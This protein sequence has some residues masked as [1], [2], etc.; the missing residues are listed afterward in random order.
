MKL[1][2]L[3]GEASGDSLASELIKAINET[4]SE[5]VECSGIGGSLMEEQGFN[6][7][8][9]M[10]QVSIVGILEVLPKIPHLMKIKKAVIQ[11]IE[12]QQPDAVITVDFPDFNFNIAK[13]LKKRGV[14]KG[15]IIHYVAPSV[16][17]WRASR[18][19]KMSEFLDG[20]MCLFPMEVPYFTEHH[21]KAAHVGH[22]IVV[23]RAK[24]ASSTAFRENNDIPDDTTT[25]GLFFGSRNNEFKD[26]ANIIK[27]AALL[28]DEDIEKINI[29][30]PTLPKLEYE[31]Q[32]I[33]KDFPLPVFVISNSDAKWSAIK[34]CDFAISV[35]GTIALELAYAGVPHVIC[36]K[37]N[38]ITSIILKLLVKVKFA[39]LANILLEKEAVPE[40]LQ[41]KCNPETIAIKAI[42]IIKSDELKKNQIEEF[43]KLE[44]KLSGADDISPSLKAANFI[45]ETIGSK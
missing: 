10:E 40:F 21:L 15:K 1:F 8:L 35:S 44:S 41:K 30:A 6:V 33:L 22:P 39:H 43:K 16:W 36:Y 38:P 29:I 25:I 42:E 19:K 4:S 3:V 7:L 37:T 34:A 5:P 24:T 13:T 23:S 31:V 17:A 32:N 45:M 26:L 9:P 12:N 2:F 28:I 18:A 14:Y 27:S 20:V 11:E